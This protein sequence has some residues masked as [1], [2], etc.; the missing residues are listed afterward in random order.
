ME[1]TSC[2]LWAMRQFGGADLGDARLSKGSYA[3]RR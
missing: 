3:W 1:Q 2:A